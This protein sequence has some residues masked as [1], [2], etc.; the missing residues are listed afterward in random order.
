MRQS[1]YKS[2]DS[3]KVVLKAGC[4][5]YSQRASD[6]L[7][8]C[9]DRDHFA[10]SARVQLG[11]TDT[12]TVRT[13][14]DLQALEPLRA[15]WQSWPG[16]RESDLDFFS[17]IVRAQA[18]GCQPHVIVLYRNGNPNAILIGM[19][20]RRKLPFR[21]G[22][23]TLCEPAV[24][25]L[26]FVYGG[27]RGNASE[28][29]CVALVKEAIRSLEGGETDIALWRNLDVQCP[30]YKCALQLPRRVS[31]DYSRSFDTHHWL[32]N[33]PKDVNSVFVNVGRN[34]RSKLR[35]KYKKMLRGTMGEVKTRCFRS[36][37]ES[38]TALLDVERIASK[39]AKRRLFGVNFYDTVPG[40][41]HMA[42][43][44]E[45]GWLRIYI[46]YAD[47][48]PIAFWVG[49]VFNGCLQADYVGYDPLWRESSPGILLFLTILD[50]LRDENIK[51]VDFGYGGSQFKRCFANTQ[52]LES[53]VYIYAPTLRCIQLNLLNTAANR[54][55]QYAKLLLRRTHCLEA[56]RRVLR[57]Y[58]VLHARASFRNASC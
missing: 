22:Y 20:R 46:L 2:T 41:E 43:A 7:K 53:R 25:V 49:T 1:R 32:I 34:Q 31:R 17:S 9:I 18:G 4:K 24:K 52:R 21:L 11:R 10:C 16:S 40:R 55:T 47:E 35:R 23:F 5:E 45:M 13:I 8:A 50:N 36:V 33:V 6:P 15:V 29:N 3:A 38:E 54:A 28:E 37:A 39:T 12:V 48:E 58:L 26:E 30:L 57:D 27:L 44:A 14:R 19:R 42:V 56:A 51:I